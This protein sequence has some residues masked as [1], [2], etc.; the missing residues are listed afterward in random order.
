ML[1]ELGC[2]ELGV[3]WQ[4]VDLGALPSLFTVRGQRGQG[5]R[6]TGKL[7]RDRLVTLGFIDPRGIVRGDLHQAMAVFASAPVEVDLRFAAG[8]G[9]GG[10]G[11]SRAAVAFADDVA[12][13]AVVTNGHVRF[14][15]VPADAGLAALVNVLPQAKPARGTLISLPIAEVDAAMTRSMEYVLAGRADI[16]DQ[17]EIL[18]NSLTGR[19]VADQDAR[20]F[21]SLVGG[22][23]LRFTEFGITSR[24]RHG[25]RR[26]C[27]HT[28][29]VVDMRVGRA[30]LHTTGDYFVAAPA[31]G[32]TVVAAL[33]EL[34]DTELG[35]LGGNRLG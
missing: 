1:I 13:L 6:L 5:G 35:R 30:V 9:V 26:R 34:R 27:A 31:D 28:V 4:A 22:K 16:P 2:T 15:R 12:F 32:A 10:R 3:A 24:D 7:A 19:G 8:R 18:V 33:T 29:Q 17:D 11:R 20:L 21:A 25:V 14:S 23:R